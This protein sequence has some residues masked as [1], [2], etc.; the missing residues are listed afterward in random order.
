LAKNKFKK[1]VKEYLKFE[2]ILS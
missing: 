1:Y 2:K